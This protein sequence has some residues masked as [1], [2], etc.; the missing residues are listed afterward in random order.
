MTHL[1]AFKNCNPDP[2]SKKWAVSVCWK[3]LIGNCPFQYYVH[4]TK[5]LL[6]RCFTKW[7]NFFNRY[8]TKFVL[9]ILRTNLPLF[10]WNENHFDEKKWV[11]AIKWNVNKW[12][13]KKKK[14]LPF[15]MHIWRNPFFNETFR[16][17][18]QRQCMISPIL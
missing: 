12:K 18:L 15:H 17:A 11:R 2:Q 13:K 4:H 1:L 14:F 7:Q 10:C 16:F 6:C 3:K 5:T 9:C 8:W